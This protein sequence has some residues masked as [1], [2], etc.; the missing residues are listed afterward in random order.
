MD[1]SQN[2][3]VKGTPVLKTYNAPK[4][5]LYGK[6]VNLTATNSRSS[7]IDGPGGARPTG[8]NV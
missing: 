8:T 2:K 1:E 4:L 5:E 3:Q 6:L 7:N